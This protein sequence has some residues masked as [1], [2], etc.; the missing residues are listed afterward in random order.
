MGQ[1]GARGVEVS[2]PH[3]PPRC[4][5]RG[6]G[7][8]HRPVRWCKSKDVFL[9]KC[10]DCEMNLSKR[11]DTWTRLEREREGG[12]KTKSRNADDK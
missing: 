11:P 8:P 12:H 3:I 7:L 9:W 1:K 5:E 2:L 4:P 10:G 6:E